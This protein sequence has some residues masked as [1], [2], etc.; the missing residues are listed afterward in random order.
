MIVLVVLPQSASPVKCINCLGTQEILH[1]PELALRECC[2]DGWAIMHVTAADEQAIAHLQRQ[3]SQSADDLLSLLGVHFRLTAVAFGSQQPQSQD[4]LSAVPSNCC[5]MDSKTHARVS[6]HTMTFC[7]NLPHASLVLWE[8]LKKR[9]HC[10][11]SPAF[12]VPHWHH[13]M[14][15]GHLDIH[16]IHASSPRS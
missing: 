12:F 16:C 13:P 7:N 1:L 3:D 9:D 5:K 8:C 10:A 15:V 6:L 14:P 11:S 4:R 2:R